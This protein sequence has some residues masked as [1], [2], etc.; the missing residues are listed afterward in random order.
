MFKMPTCPP[1]TLD[2]YYGDEWLGMC[3]MGVWLGEIHQS[4]QQSG[5][6]ILAEFPS[7]TIGGAAEGV[8][9]PHSVRKP[10]SNA[11]LKRSL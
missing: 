4:K 6:R 1:P 8:R 2:R 3:V 10:R 11:E 9:S 5:F 7:T